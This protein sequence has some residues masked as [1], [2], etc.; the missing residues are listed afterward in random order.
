MSASRRPPSSPPVDLPA[1]ASVT[2]PWGSFRQY[3]HNGACTVSL[4][5]VKPGQRL[6]FQSHCHRSE[7]WIVLDE[8]CEVQIGDAVHHP[9]AG[10][11]F[12]IVANTP[13]RLS[14]RGPEVRV[15]EVAFGDWRQ[16]DI[17]RYDDDYGR[18]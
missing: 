13:H 8:Q 12:W 15:L 9:P 17:A 5:T 18:G 6:S 11:E 7:L 4:M 1:I 3:R 10:A 14:S 2:R 16:E